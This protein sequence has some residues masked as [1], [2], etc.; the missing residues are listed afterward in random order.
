MTAKRAEIGRGVAVAVAEI[1]TSSVGDTV[2]EAVLVDVGGTGVAVAVMVERAIVGSG[3]NAAGFGDA[4]QA[5]RNIAKT[6]ASRKAKKPLLFCEFTIN[7]VSMLGFLILP[8]TGNGFTQCVAMFL[9]NL[10]RA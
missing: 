2:D 10:R 7:D 5:P 3:V 1:L 4:L 8:L 9:Y 6:Q